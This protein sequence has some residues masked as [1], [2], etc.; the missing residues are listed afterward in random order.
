M[1]SE[2][3][4]WWEQPRVGAG[5]WGRRS[6]FWW[7]LGGF[8]RGFFV[9]GGIPSCFLWLQGPAVTPWCSQSLGVLYCCVLVLCCLPVSL[10]LLW[11]CSVLPDLSP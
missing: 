4:V 1:G 7:L 9:T 8:Y 3:C 11:G 2:C 10:L 6:Q 5:A